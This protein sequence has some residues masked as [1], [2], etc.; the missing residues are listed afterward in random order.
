MKLVIIE[1][2]YKGNVALHERYLRACIR[3]CLKRGESPYASHRMLTDALNDNVPEERALGIEAGFAWAHAGVLHEGATQELDDFEEVKHVF[4]VDFGYS[5]GMLLA[6]RKFCDA[7]AEE[8]A[9]SPDDPF[10]STPQ[11]FV[12]RDL[13]QDE[14]SELSVFSPN[15]ACLLDREPPGASEETRRRAREELAAILQQ[16]GKS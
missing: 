7:Y 5:T 1:S 11:A 3:D 12:L 10:F 8:R 9:L 16:R 6:K 4:Y 2:P 13:S 15:L 14:L